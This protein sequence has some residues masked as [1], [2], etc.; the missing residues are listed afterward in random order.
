[1]DKMEF[2]SR[3]YDPAY[4]NA[5]MREARR[6]RN[7]VLLDMFKAIFDGRLTARLFGKSETDKTSYHGPSPLHG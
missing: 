5:V 6:M 7:E 1:M 3:A 4:I 2:D